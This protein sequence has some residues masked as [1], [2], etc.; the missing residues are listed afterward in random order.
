MNLQP[1]LIETALKIVFALALILAIMVLLTVGARRILNRGGGIKGS[2]V[3]VLENRY[4]GVK[5]YISV[6][7]IPGS[8]L[9]LGITNDN[10]SLLT[11]IDEEKDILKF[12]KQSLQ[13][14]PLSFSKQLFKISTRSKDGNKE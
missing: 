13:Q 7:E 11:K 4:V 6:I 10:I 8:I 14:E 5:K 3:D 2:L 12:R 1:D 9:I